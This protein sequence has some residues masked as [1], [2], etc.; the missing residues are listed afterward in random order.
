M[1]HR[2]AAL[3]LVV[4]ACAAWAQTTSGTITGAVADPSG[5]VIAQAVIEATNA[6]T[7][8]VIRTTSTAT[9]NYA[10]A[11]LPP[12]PYELR[13][14]VPGFKTYLRGGLTVETAA[15]VRIDVTLEV[16][17]SNESISVTAE[18]PLLKT[19]SGEL[20]HRV[21]A[22][23]LNAVPILPLGGSAST[24]GI[25]NPWALALELPG[26]FFLGGTTLKVNGAPSNTTAFRIEGMDATNYMN[27][28]FTASVQ[29]SVDAIEEVAVQTSNFAAEFGAV[30]GGLFNV[31]MRS[32]T[33]NYHGT[34]YDYFVNE[35]LNAQQA[36]VN[37][38]STQRRNNYGGTFGGPVWIP[39]LY[40]GRNRTFFFF[41]F[42]EFRESSEVRTTVLSVPTALYRQGDFSQVITGS[43][44]NGVPRNVQVGGRDYADPLGRVFPSGTI[45]DPSTERIVASGANN[46]LVR[47]PFPQNRIA[48]TRFD[49]VAV[50]I[51]NLIPPPVG[52]RANEIFNNYNNPWDGSRVTNIPSL[53]L[54][55]SIGA[56]GRLSVYWS[57]TGSDAQYSTLMAADGL[58]QPISGARGYFIHTQT[59]RVNYDHM[60]KPTLLAHF[61]VGYLGQLLKDD[62][63]T[64]GYDAF[65]ELGLRG[66]TVNRNFPRITTSVSANTGGMAN[67]GPASQAHD[68]QQKPT[69]NASLTWI[70]DNHTFKIGGEWRAE[71]YPSRELSLLAGSYG[72]VPTTTGQTAFQGLTASQGSFGFG[73]ASFLLGLVDSVTLAVP[74]DTKRGKQQWA[75]FIQD[76]W[77][78]RR[79][80]TLDYGLRW[81]YGTY[82]SEQYGR[83]GNFD[84]VV[85]NPTTGN[86]PGATVFEG[87]GPGK[88]GCRF[89][90]NYPYGIGPRLGV[91]WQVNRK[92]VIRGGLGVVYDSTGTAAGSVTNTQSG[93][94][95]GYG[96]SIFQLSDG[97]PSSVRPEWPTFSPGLYP[98]SGTVGA[99]AQYLDQNSGRPA[100]QVQWSFSIQREFHQNF[101]L[102][103]SYVGNHGVWWRSTADGA[104]A[105]LNVMSEQRLNAYGFNLQT[106]SDATLLNTQWRN[107]S[108]AQRSLL[109]GR[110]IILP[111]AGFPDTQ[112]VRQAL[113]PFPQF[114]NAILSAGAPLSRT[115]YEAL[116]LTATQRL[117][118]GLTLTANYT[119]SKTLDDLAGPPDVFNR[120]NG[121]TLTVFDQP[122]SFRLTGQYTSPVLRGGG[123]GFL[124]NRLVAALLSE[125]GVGVYLQY[126]TPTLLT[127]PA[128]AT[129]PALSNWLGRGPGAAVRVPGESL[130]AT[131]WTDYNGKVHPEPIDINCHC[132]DPAKTIVLNRNAWTNPPVGVWSP[133]A[134]RY[135]D[136]RS[137][138]LPRENLNV[139]RNFRIREGVTFNIRAEFTNVLNRNYLPNPSTANFLGS[140]T[141]VNGVYTGG[142]GT[143]NT[144]AGSQIVGGTTIAPRSGILVA[145]LTF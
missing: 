97:I 105:P 19:E 92:T 31:S 71:G 118:H 10:L 125:W 124:G 91:A 22:S 119:W 130:W 116:Q 128:A 68:Y 126:V 110:G 36:F 90:D 9:G 29:P 100:R 129:N 86:R 80:L 132:Y 21:T 99:A 4:L 54:D 40:N 60:F 34:A 75:L 7:G 38:K 59:E 52:A 81:D 72:F 33:N 89:A 5:A 138:S 87:N 43:G 112:T 76:S 122:H 103:A 74:A 30:G 11:Q 17:A 83:V 98:T 120:R 15:V 41:N 107:L 53:K 121:K 123:G 46:F 101:V 106:V 134:G 114:T 82:A 117:W 47:D 111:Y 63:P 51:Q 56:K 13:V 136:F 8:Q 73:Y 49:P 20:S 85:L 145:R 3:A 69:A 66:A 88:C 70:K 139:S 67:M 16:G 28:G 109:A 133:S 140:P 102:E 62:A 57:T 6:D 35:F 45:F 32:G 113:L 1:H 141:Q 37:R 93:A 95:P 137:I 135:T 24:L 108:T 58:P 18:A 26:T 142:F 55:Q 144:T 84:P 115:W 65:K 48:P 79:N 2:K 27:P 14:A 61:G 25:R 96:G 94:T 64:I 77:K 143:I 39:K 44:V 127:L 104:L 23:S 131:N 12:G 50:R 78:V 42:E